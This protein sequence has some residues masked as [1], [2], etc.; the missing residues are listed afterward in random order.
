VT[1]FTYDANGNLV[2]ETRTMS[3]P[4]GLAP[5]DAHQVR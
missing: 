1:A 4:A 2:T 3:T 5:L